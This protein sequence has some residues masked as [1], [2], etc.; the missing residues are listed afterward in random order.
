MFDWVLNMPLDKYFHQ[1]AENSERVGVK[2]QY[3]VTEAA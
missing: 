2:F 1:N 3:K